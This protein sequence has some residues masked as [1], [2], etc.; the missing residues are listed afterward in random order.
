MESKTSHSLNDLRN[1]YKHMIYKIDKILKKLSLDN[2]LYIDAEFSGITY[3][4]YIFKRFNNVRIIVGESN[5]D[6]GDSITKKLGI[7][8]VKCELGFFADKSP[9]VEIKEN[10]RGTHIFIIQSGTNDDKYSLNDYSEQLLAIVDACKRSGT[11]SIT[12]IIPYYPNARSDKRDAPRV[13]IMAKV[14]T[15][16][17]EKSGVDRIITMDLHSGQIQG[18]SD[19]PIDNLYAKPLIAKY[20]YRHFFK[21]L[22]PEQINDNNVF[23]SPDTGSYKRVNAYSETFKID[24]I[25]LH[26]E[27]DYTKP[28]CVSRST[29]IENNNNIFGKKCFIFD[30]MIDTAGTLISTI[31]E[32]TKVGAIEVIPVTTHGIFSDPAIERINECQ[33]IKQLI[34]TNTLPQKK[35]LEKCTKKVHVVNVAPLFAYTI[36]CLRFYGSISKLFTI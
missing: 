25:T 16:K 6:L 26:K 35:M 3:D 14:T 32:L 24:N 17:L 8:K 15:R 23:I 11:K 33:S 29:I 12:V 34:V 31:N 7:H 9:Y 1:Q 2:K 20:L 18:F 21:N 19:N 13:P 30:D 27:R 28:N 10:V 4:Q 22:T 36:V 5:I